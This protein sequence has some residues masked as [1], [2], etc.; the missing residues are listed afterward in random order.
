MKI[1]LAFT[2]DL[3]GISLLILLLPS[4]L[5]PEKENTTA[6]IKELWKLKSNFYI[7]NKIHIQFI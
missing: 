3:S 5:Q 4:V 6:Y 1:L 7:V 2:D